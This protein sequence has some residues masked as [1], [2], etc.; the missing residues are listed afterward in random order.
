V[1]I[2]DMRLR[3]RYGEVRAELWGGKTVRE[4]R[5]AMLTSCS[6]FSGS[7][8]DDRASHGAP[9]PGSRA[10]EPALTPSTRGANPSNSKPTAG[11]AAH[12]GQAPV[13]PGSPILRRLA[14]AS[15]LRHTRHSRA[16]ASSRLAPVL[17]LEVPLVRRTSASQS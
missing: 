7:L 4:H 12:L 9:T 1:F 6:N 11:S 13:D 15:G 17:A 8:A 5:S 3:E 14:C 16:L 2:T 10:R